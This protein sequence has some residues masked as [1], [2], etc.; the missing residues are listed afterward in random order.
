M[1]IPAHNSRK[2]RWRSGASNPRPAIPPIRSRPSWLWSTGRCEER[3]RRVRI[4]RPGKEKALPE[5][6]SEVAERVPL[7]GHLDAL[8]HDLERER[9][10][11][12]DHR[13][14]EALD[15]RRGA[16]LQEG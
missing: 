8:G 11:Q 1:H 6:T 14:G 16:L 12:A 13:G 5:V 2:S 3:D 15:L 9:G 10:A 4:H 7:L